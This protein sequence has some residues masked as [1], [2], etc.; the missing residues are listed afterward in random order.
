MSPFSIRRRP[1]P[2]QRVSGAPRCA[3]RQARQ[4]SGAEVSDLVAALGELPAV[5]GALVAVDMEMLTAAMRQE[6]S[7]ASGLANDTDGERRSTTRAEHPRLHRDRV[8]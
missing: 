3:R 1:V 2:G 4:R 5:G 6:L 8:T 7:S